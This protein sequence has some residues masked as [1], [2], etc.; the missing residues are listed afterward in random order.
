MASCA[1]PGQRLAG[2]L[3]PEWTMPLR[4]ERL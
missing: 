1:R 4:R 2:R 3:D